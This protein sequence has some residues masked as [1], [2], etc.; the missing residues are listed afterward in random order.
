[1]IQTNE[2][3]TCHIVGLTKSQS[4]SKPQFKHIFEKFVD[5][6]LLDVVNAIQA[7]T[8]FPFYI[9]I[10][11]TY[12]GCFFCTSVYV[13]LF[14]YNV[15]VGVFCEKG[16]CSPST[17]LFCLVIGLVNIYVMLGGVSSNCCLYGG[18]SIV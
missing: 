5:N 12:I 16:S 9:Y 4:Q 7:V 8:K 11:Y 6:P 10:Y 17:L 1:M 2:S 14:Q 3:V 15:G 13:G 18:K